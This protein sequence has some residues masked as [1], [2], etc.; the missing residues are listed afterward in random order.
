[1]EIKLYVLSYQSF[2]HGISNAVQGDNK[3][4]NKDISD[5]LFLSHARQ[6]QRP[7]NIQNEILS[8][9]LL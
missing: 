3:S 8:S 4:E 9:I 1:V 2:F 5:N 7:G 6:Y